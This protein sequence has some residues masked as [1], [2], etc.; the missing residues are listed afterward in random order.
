M[1]IKQFI[2]YSIIYIGVI[3]VLVFMNVSGNFEMKLFGLSLNLPIAIWFIAPLFIYAVVSIIHISYYSFGL[4]LQRRAIR[5]D[6][7]LYDEFAREILLGFESNKDFKSD[8]FENPSKI[9]KFLSPWTTNY[10]PNID[11]TPLKEA[12][13]IVKAIKNGE[14]VDLKKLKISKESKI[15]I[16]NELNRL[17]SD[18]NYYKELLNDKKLQNALLKEEACRQLLQKGSFL[19]IKKELNLTNDEDILFVIRRYLDEK[20]FEVSRE[21]LYLLM[22]QGKFDA[23]QYIELAKELS[24]KIEPDNLITIFDRLKAEKELAKEAYMYLLY[25]FGMID[26]LREIVNFSDSECDKF[27]TLL[28]LRDSGKSI[29]ISYFY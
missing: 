17:K 21:D 6:S 23:K 2:A 28:F 22:L 16:T 12:V 13:E 15:Y 20:E 18:E 19:E 29:P 24:K 5:R 11:E 8:L 10:E 7:S 27:K 26:K 4:Y 1:K 3:G 25:E 14:Y 9:T